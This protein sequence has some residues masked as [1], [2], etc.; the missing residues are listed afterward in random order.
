MRQFIEEHWKELAPLSTRKEML[1]YFTLQCG[2]S[3]SEEKE[4]ANTRA[5]KEK[6]VRKT[7]EQ[8]LSRG[9][10]AYIDSTNMSADDKAKA[11]GLFEKSMAEKGF[12]PLS[13]TLPL[14]NTLNLLLGKTP[15]TTDSLAFA[16][17]EMSAQLAKMRE[18]QK[19]LIDTGIASRFIASAQEA[20]D[21]K[22]VAVK[23]DNGK[24]ELAA[25]PAP[26]D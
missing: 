4:R 10:T 16:I 3:L 23:S 15:A 13:A 5:R 14:Y 11:C 24:V 22:L 6:R 17:E 25:I 18:Q 19:S 26:A 9:G 8:A 2:Y 21:A 7:A 1:A 12:Y 20:I